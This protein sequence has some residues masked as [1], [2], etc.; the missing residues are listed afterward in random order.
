LVPPFSN[1]KESRWRA[2]SKKSKFL[3]VAMAIWARAKG[4]WKGKAFVARKAV[5]ALLSTRN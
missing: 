1:W 5:V 4:Q 3:A 2:W